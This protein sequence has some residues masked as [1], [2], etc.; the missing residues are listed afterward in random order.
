MVGEIC[1]NSLQ[2]SH[3]YGVYHSLCEFRTITNLRYA[4][5]GD[6]CESN[7]K[8]HIMWFT[9]LLCEVSIIADVSYGFSVSGLFLT[10]TL[11]L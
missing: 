1:A 4:M 11:T 3:N 6:I 9:T 5:T 7:Y 10:L 2:N 8:T